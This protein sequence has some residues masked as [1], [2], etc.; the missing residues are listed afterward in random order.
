M[1]SNRPIAH[2]FSRLLRATPAG[3]LLETSQARRLRDRLYGGYVAVGDTKIFAPGRFKEWYAT[4]EPLTLRWLEHHLHPRMTAINVGAHIGFVAVR[5]AQLVGP[6]GRVIAIEPAPE[7]ARYLRRNIGRYGDRCEVIEAAAG[8]T[9][10]SVL[11]KLTQSSDSHGIYDHPLTTTASEIPVRRVA[12]DDLVVQPDFV[13]IDV[14]GAELDVLAGMQ[15]IL[16]AMPTLLVEWAPACQVASGRE[17][18]ELTGVLAGLG[19]DLVVLDD[20]NGI[21]RSPDQ[22]RRLL[23]KGLLP[24]SW[25]AN[26]AC[27]RR[28]PA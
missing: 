7:N 13:T 8:A 16:A 4:F 24:P 3:A 23:K 9:S 2:A 21:E 1:T 11:L 18:D 5:M 15:R 26:I 27:T 17:P 19:Y 12:L 14:E 22:V 28:D 6:S 10:G 20:V 25:Y